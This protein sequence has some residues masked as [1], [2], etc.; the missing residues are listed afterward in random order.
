MQPSRRCSGRSRRRR[1][2]ASRWAAG[3]RCSVH[4]P[5]LAGRRIHC[6]H[7]RPGEMG[8]RTE[9]LTGRKI[10]QGLPG[11]LAD[12]ANYLAETLHDVAVGQLVQDPIVH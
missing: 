1:L 12:A 5:Q 11:R 9:R 3:T 2:R 7:D 10:R 8:E 6:D 4:H